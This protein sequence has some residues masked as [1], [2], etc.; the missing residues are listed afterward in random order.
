ML[1][2]LAL[3]SVTAGMTEENKEWS[4]QIG[5]MN[6]SL[7]DQR[8][9]TGA[10]NKTG[11]YLDDNAIGINLKLNGYVNDLIAIGIG[12]NEITFDSDGSVLGQSL[13]DLE[14]SS[15]YLS[16]EF[17][18]GKTFEG[19]GSLE[20]GAS[21]LESIKISQGGISA[22]LYKDSSD[23]YWSIGGGCK[24]HMNEN[25]F[26]DLGYRY[27]DYGTLKQSPGWLNVEDVDVITNSVDLSIGW[28]F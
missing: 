8:V 3:G 6:A 4:V 18:G 20:F 1:I 7:V 19:Y 26:L 9:I 11:D 14:A 17:R 13:T 25:M 12:H 21:D 15:T 23:T 10:D 24:W 16:I 5:V 28:K 27:R 2:C 22:K